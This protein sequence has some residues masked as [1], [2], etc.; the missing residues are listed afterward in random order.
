MNNETAQI[1]DAITVEKFIAADAEVIFPY[2]TDT[3]KVKAWY[4]V[5]AELDARPG[6]ICRLDH[7]GQ[8]ASSVYHSLGEFIEVSPYTRVVYTW[9]YTNP[10]MGDLPQNGNST[11]QVDLI[12]QDGGTLVRL[13]HSG[14][15]AN[16][17]EGFGEGNMSIL[18]MLAELLEKD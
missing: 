14:L 18:V 7:E 10:D 3:E 9:G 13:A 6:G 15:N 11:I 5:D 2:F 16:V 8:D 4:C 1:T 12:P 17:R